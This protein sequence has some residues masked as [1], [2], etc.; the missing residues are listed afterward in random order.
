[1]WFEIFKAGT[2]T[3][4]AGNTRTWTEADLDTIVAKYD[5]ATHEAPVVIGHPK[6]NAPAWGWIDALKRE[7]SALLAQAK[8]LVPE[9]V[10]MV[11]KGLF[12]KRSISLYP[13]LTL[14]HVGFLGAM[15]PA[16]KGLKDVAFTGTETTE[17]EFEERTSQPNPEEEAMS[18]ELEDKIKALSDQ[19]AAFAEQLTAKDAENQK[20]KADLAATQA[21][22]D[23][24]R[25]ARA[26]AEFT[27]FCDD[28]VDGGTMTP[29]QASLAVDFMEILA[30]QPE[31]EFAE[32]EDKKAKKAPLEA[33]KTFLKTLPTQ[34][35]FGEHATKGRASGT[36]QGSA[37]EKIEAHIS[38]KRAADK[39]LSYGEALTAVQREYPDLA[40]EYAE[41]IRQ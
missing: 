13:D 21:G 24:E 41:E 5:P 37:A 2:H 28:L 40:R 11:K 4:S 39:T 19:V 23:A 36:V 38:E 32:G 8:D 20:L 14:R 33:F 6:D 34:V 31:H 9:F 25:A 10:E 1:M 29:A 17:I 7:G 26:R 16:V 3:D 22:L 12:K 18:K 35:Q 30:D 27:S 15:P